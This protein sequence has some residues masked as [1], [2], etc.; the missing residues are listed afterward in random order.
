VRTAEVRPPEVRPDEVRPIEVRLNEVRPPEVRLLE[1]GPAEVHPVEVR[2][3][4]VHPVEVCPSEVRPSE[5]R[6]AEDRRAGVRPSEVRLAVDQLTV[7]GVLT[8]PLVPRFRALL[9]HLDV[10][11]VSHEAPP[12]VAAARRGQVFKRE[13]AGAPAALPAEFHSCCRSPFPNSSDS[14]STAGQP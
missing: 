10:L 4:E 1:E 12:R 11:V 14:L 2:S 6:H 7:R 13:V 8:T 5:V 9:K 3:D